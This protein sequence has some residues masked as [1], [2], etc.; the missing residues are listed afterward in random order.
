MNKA[1]FKKYS[2]FVIALTVLAVGGLACDNDMKKPSP[3]DSHEKSFYP[4]IVSLAPSTTE[5]LYALGLGDNVVGVTRYCY[6]PEEA[7]KKPKVGG[8]FDIN[9]EI[10]LSLRPDLAVILNVHNEPKKFFKDRGIKTITVNNKTITGIHESII[11]IGD[12][13]GK[14][15]EAK[16]ILEDIRKRTEKIRQSCAGLDKPSVMIVVGRE[17]ENDKI[18]DVYIAGKNIFYDDMIELAGGK[19]AFTKS[20]IDYPKVTTEGI[21]IMDP[22]VIIEILPELDKSGLT[23]EDIIKQWMKM[24]R[25]SAVKNKRVHVFTEYHTVIPGPRYIDTLEDFAKIFHPAQ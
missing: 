13:C 5:T 9:Y 4:R 8:Y 11:N 14:S 18:S 15:A 25:L 1:L 24:Q 22:E 2:F 16:S 17:I 6:Y 23:K 21:L 10:I 20:G 12:A 3:S 19:N 7:Q